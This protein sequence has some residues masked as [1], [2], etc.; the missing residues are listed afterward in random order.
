MRCIRAVV[1]KQPS[2]HTHL[3]CWGMISAYIVDHMQACLD[4]SATSINDTELRRPRVFVTSHKGDTRASKELR[5]SR[6]IRYPSASSSGPI[7]S[8]SITVST[9]GTSCHCCRRSPHSISDI[10][11]QRVVVRRVSNDP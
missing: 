11:V 6:I 2:P 9:G 4:S 5:P 7:A 1:V 3:H 10:A 8:P